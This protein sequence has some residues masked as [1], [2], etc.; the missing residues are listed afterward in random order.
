MERNTRQRGAIRRAFQ[1]AD[2]PLSTAE[3]L[4]LARSEVTGLGIATVYRNIR[5]L[6]DEGWLIPV[7]LPGES[8]RYELRGKGHHHH[9]HCSRCDRVFDVGSCS[10]SVHTMIPE[11]FVLDRH[12]IV[13]GGLCAECAR[14]T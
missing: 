8:Q 6:V 2:R 3:V 5:T 4:D 9:F 11:G 1:R 7:E 14:A 13:L 12:L 10:G